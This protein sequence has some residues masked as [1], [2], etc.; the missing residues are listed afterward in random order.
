MTVLEFIQSK[1]DDAR[2]VLLRALVNNVILLDTDEMSVG[3]DG[4]I[5][6]VILHS[7]TKYDFVKISGIFSDFYWAIGTPLHGD[8]G[9][10]FLIFPQ[11][12]DE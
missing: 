7:F 6:I 2:R 4:R 1:N 3:E 11:K 8:H 12:E 9:F 5:R 10:E